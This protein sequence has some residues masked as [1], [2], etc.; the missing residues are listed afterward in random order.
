M[1]EL[2]SIMSSNT[3]NQLVYASS[4]KQV[5]F[6]SAC[7]QLN[8]NPKDCISAEQ[9]HADG[10]AIV[11]RKDLGQ[12][13]SRVDAL[14]TTEK[15]IPLVVR[16]ADCAPILIHDPAK[17][18]LALVHAG[19]KGTEL[20]ITFKT[21][22]K[23]KKNGYDPRGLIVKIGPT[24]GK[25]CYPVDLRKENLE[26]LVKSGVQKEKV[27]IA[28]ECTCCNRDKYFSYRGDG[29]KTGRMFLVAVL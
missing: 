28:L 17:E 13:I 3:N 2:T 19:R 24:I 6:D 5:S 25:C 26:Q 11:S 9:I 23:I 10:I 8:V 14:I 18:V 20:E 1:I 15:G 12:R 4:N 16:T 22:Q 21:I 29:P 7:Q 27:E